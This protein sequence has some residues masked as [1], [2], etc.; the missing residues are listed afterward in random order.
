MINF[1]DV[2]KQN[3]KEHNPNW[4]QIRDDPCRILITGDSGFGKTISL[5][6]LMSHQPNVD[7][8]WSI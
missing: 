8:I 4:P 6:K 5:I 3:V 7:E 2:T 1:D